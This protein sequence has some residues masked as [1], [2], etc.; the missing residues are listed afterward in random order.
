MILGKK[1][2]LYI[3]NKG[4]MRGNGDS[5]IKI[6]ILYGCHCLRIGK[7]IINTSSNL[8][9]FGEACGG[10]RFMFN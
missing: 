1:V 7:D 6:K 8:I 10:R 2:R 9:S 4:P 5:K 3:D